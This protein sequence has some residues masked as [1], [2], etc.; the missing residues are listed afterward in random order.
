[1]PIN[2]NGFVHLSANIF[3]FGTPN[4]NKYNYFRVIIVS[5]RNLNN[6]SSV[7]IHSIKFFSN[8][9]FDIGSN[10][11]LVVHNNISIFNSET[12]NPNLLLFRVDVG[13]NIV[14]GGDITNF[15]ANVTATGSY[16][17]T[18]GNYITSN[19]QL[20]GQYIFL[21]WS[22]AFSR[23]INTA[24]GYLNIFT[25]NTSVPGIYMYNSNIYGYLTAGIDTTS[26]DAYLTF[27]DSAARII[28]TIQ[29]STTL[30]TYMELNINT[31]VYQGWRTN[32]NFIVGN[33][34]GIGTTNPRVQLDVQSKIYVGGDVNV[35]TPQL[36]KYGGSG[37]R[38]IL[39]SGDD[40]THP[41]SIGINSAVLWYSAP[42]GTSHN[43]FINAVS[44]LSINPTVVTV[45]QSL[46]VN[47][48]SFL[49]GNVGIGT[50]SSTDFRLIVN[51]KVSVSGSTAAPSIGISGGLGDRIILFPGT[52]AQY[53]Y[54]I[55]VNTS[56]YWFSCPS[57][58]N[59]IWFTS[60]VSNM[61]LDTTGTLTYLN[62]TFTLAC[63]I[64]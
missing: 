33:N 42:V 54:S 20:L 63:V 60:N 41:Y 48:T 53:P 22:N 19:G 4:N 64:S 32:S 43:F 5:G 24:G 14:S 23:G 56:T 3:R 45:N 38:I 52:A 35:N 40:T 30:S 57:N 8:T 47:S 27:Y 59:Y 55:G 37:D 21:N 44:I 62:V 31:A 12:N 58:V 9:N 25:T 18:N 46:T 34:V 26:T 6:T 1:M 11:N 39:Y 51:G 15:G 17:S 28:S 13:G 49:S 50:A 36:G 7:I 16:T 61:F 2:T 10:L 29:K